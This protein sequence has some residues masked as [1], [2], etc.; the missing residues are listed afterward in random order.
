MR[1]H[2]HKPCSVGDGMNQLRTPE[3]ERMAFALGY[4]IGRR[5]WTID[6]PFSPKEEQIMTDDRLAYVCGYDL[7]SYHTRE[8]IGL[9][10]K[11]IKEKV[12]QPA[13]EGIR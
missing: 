5:Y 2:P 9:S 3:K 1:E 4:Y 11:E 6:F 10:E 13:S 12:C 8:N 7:G